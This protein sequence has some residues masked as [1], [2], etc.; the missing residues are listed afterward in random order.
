ML[1]DDIPP[2]GAPSDMIDVGDGEAKVDSGTGVK[3]PPEITVGV[4]GALNVVDGAARVVEGALKVVEP[5]KAGAG[6][7]MTGVVRLGA[8]VG[9]G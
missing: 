3:L 2:L 6:F 5:L 8:G 1:P 4:D 9:E 7:V